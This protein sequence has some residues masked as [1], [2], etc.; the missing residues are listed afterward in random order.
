MLDKRGLDF[1]LALLGETSQT[2]PKAFIAAR[3]RF[4]KQIVQYGYVESREEY[5]KWLQRGAIVISTAKQE[6]FGISI[7]EAIRFG[8][9]P[10]LPERLSYP[11]ILPAAFHSDCL[12][13]NREE[14]LD[15]LVF[16][17][18]NHSRFSARFSN[19][20]AALAESAA[21]FAWETMIPHY[22]EE[23]ERL[24]DRRS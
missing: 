24:V 18:S 2:F 3:R 19:M 10:L 23:L 17:L 6:N 11:E 15:K 5:R 20:R 9:L 13:R 16:L 21:R 22:D 7:I 8:C 14:L 1:R 12:Y 4:Q